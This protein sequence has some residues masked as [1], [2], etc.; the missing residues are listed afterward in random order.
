MPTDH[1]TPLTLKILSN[2]PYLILDVLPLAT[3]PAKFSSQ[4]IDDVENLKEVAGVTASGRR[5]ESTAKL[6]VNQKSWNI[7]V[8]N[9]IL[10]IYD[11]VDYKTFY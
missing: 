4:N 11:Q 8:T 7:A 1:K 9:K 10:N 6:A 5:S 3:C 2:I